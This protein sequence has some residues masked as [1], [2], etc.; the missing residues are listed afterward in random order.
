M[1]FSIVMSCAKTPET[2]EERLH[3]LSDRIVSRG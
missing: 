3:R 2:A 1:S